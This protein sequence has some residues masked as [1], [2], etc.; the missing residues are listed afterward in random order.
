MASSKK[1]AQLVEDLA[2]VALRLSRT[3]NPAPSFLAIALERYK[4]DHDEIV[5]IVRKHLRLVAKR[6]RGMGHTIVLLSFHYY[7][8]GRSRKPAEMDEQRA[9]RCICWGA[10]GRNAAYGLGFV[11]P[12]RQELSRIY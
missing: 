8:C 5:D 2:E 7:D 11:T 10:G 12:E 9:A 3:G 1:T 4:S 6:L